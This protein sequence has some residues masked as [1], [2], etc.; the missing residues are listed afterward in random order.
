MRKVARAAQG[1]SIL[2][3]NQ[4]AYTV[5]LSSEG[6]EDV[7]TPAGIRPAERFSASY[8]SERAKKP[9][10][11]KVWLATDEE[12]LPYRIEIHGEIEGR[13]SQLVA[14]IH[15]YEPGEQKSERIKSERIKKTRP[16]DAAFDQ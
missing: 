16:C 12:R 1:C 13:T 6:E 7:R 2:Y 11:G 5:W 14:R 8:A 3:S 15:L 4:R 9:L 10:P